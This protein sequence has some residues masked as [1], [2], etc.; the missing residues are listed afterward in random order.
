MNMRNPKVESVSTYLNLRDDPATSTRAPVEIRIA[1]RWVSVNR[2][3]GASQVNPIPSFSP[4]GL[5]MRSS[6]GSTVMLMMKATI[7]PAPAISPSSE[8]PRYAVGIKEKKPAA[9]AAAASVSGAPARSAAFDSAI[10]RSS[11]T[12][13]H[14]ELNAEINPYADAQ[15][16]K[17]IEIT[18]SAARP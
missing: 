5:M 16:A 4:G 1:V 8:M 12:V 18:L 3:T 10:R 14:A 6:D 13:A 7:I 15:A 17:A 11:T 2:S 9:V